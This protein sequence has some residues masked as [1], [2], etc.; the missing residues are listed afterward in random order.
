[1]RQIDNTYKKTLTMPQLSD[2]GKDKLSQL[3]T[4]AEK[5]EII[6][7]LKTMEGFKRKLLLLLK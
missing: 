2:K 5:H 7:I 1:M 4:E 6:S 3:F